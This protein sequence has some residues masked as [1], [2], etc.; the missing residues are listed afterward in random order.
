MTE[1]ILIKIK[2]T[3]K[4]KFNKKTARF[5][6]I[7]GGMHNKY[8]TLFLVLMTIIFWKDLFTELV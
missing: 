3:K 2:Q 4:N 5:I 7:K 1:L 8:C 6:Q